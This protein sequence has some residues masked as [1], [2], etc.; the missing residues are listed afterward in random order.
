MEKNL[1]CV[2]L[3][4]Y[5]ATSNPAD[6]GSVCGSPQVTGRI[7]GGSDAV[8]GEWPW[9]VSLMQRKEDDFYHACG[10]SLITP[11]WVLTAAHCFNGDLD[12][13]NYKVILGLYKLQSENPNGVVRSVKTVEIHSQYKEKWHNWD[14]AL[15]KLSS[16]VPYTKYILPVCLPSASVTFPCGLECWVA[17]WGDIH[18]GVGLPS[19]GTLQNV[20]VPLIDHETCDKILHENSDLSNANTLVDDTMIC[21]GY[22]K[23]GKD[24]CQGDSGGPLVCKV[25][26]TWY[27]PGV[28]SWGS[29][30]A[31]PNR[32]G[33]YTL[34]TSYQSWIRSYIPELSFYD[35][36]NIPQPS[37]K[38]KGNMNVSCYLLTLLIITASVLRYL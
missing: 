24:S 29:G 15:V 16:P 6:G 1:I 12:F 25:N 33:V 2:L 36:A 23:G 37:Q 34:V 22:T 35:V 4:L 10:G 14:I 38:C 27:Q 28:V 8:E 18:C 3:V 31:L 20:K 13:R 30:C 5:V 9:Q 19:P 7:V 11:E 32:P 26:G 17:G 21:A